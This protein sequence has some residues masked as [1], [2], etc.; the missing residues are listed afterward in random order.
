MSFPYCIMCRRASSA[1]SSKKIRI[2]RR[3][4]M[5]MN[6]KVRA[7]KE[8]AKAVDIPEI[9]N[10]YYTCHL[11]KHMINNTITSNFY[12]CN[13]IVSGTWNNQ[14]G[15]TNWVKTKHNSLVLNTTVV[16]QSNTSIVC[17]SCGSEPQASNWKVVT[18]VSGNLQQ[19]NNMVVS[20][21]S[22]SQ[23]SKL[24]ESQQSK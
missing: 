10:I 2:A 14:S 18:S 1:Y 5:M 15:S 11:K 6:I 3:D 20:W 12:S 9:E 22:Q 23:T 24:W 17:H 21:S 4:R 13:F 16:Y 19:V 8:T 7:A